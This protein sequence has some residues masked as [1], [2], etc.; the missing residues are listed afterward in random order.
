[1]GRKLPLSSNL[2]IIYRGRTDVVGLAMS[3]VRKEVLFKSLEVSVECFF[4]LFIW[5]G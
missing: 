3:K 1:M 4:G 2:I 5:M